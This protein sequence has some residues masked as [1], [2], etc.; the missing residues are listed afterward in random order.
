MTELPEGW[1]GL[2]DDE[3]RECTIGPQPECAACGGACCAP[4]KLWAEVPE[5]THLANLQERIEAEGYPVERVRGLMRVGDR[6]MAKFDCRAYGAPCE[7]EPK[8][9]LCAKFPLP[10][11]RSDVPETARRSVR[12]LCPLLRRLEGERQVGAVCS[13]P[14]R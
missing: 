13:R 8:P 5:D 10:F 6:L 1:W 2:T 4:G 3:L 9:R 14:D 12:A 11:L 7:V